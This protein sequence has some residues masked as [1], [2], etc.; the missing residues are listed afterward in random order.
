VAIRLGAVRLVTCASP[1][2]LARRGIPARPPDLDGHCCVT[3]TALSTPERW[4]FA[5]HD[6][7]LHSRL[8][9]NPAEAAI[10]AVEAGLGI[11]RVL[12]YQV[13]PLLRAGRLVTLLDDFA[14][15]VVPVSLIH[16]GQGRMPH[17]LRAFLDFAA[18]RLRATLK[19]LETAAATDA[20]PLS[21]TSSAR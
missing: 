21:G 17:K 15:D 8:T 16:A 1:A 5:G 2:Y 9:V 4:S 7:S 20:D 11:T 18:P 10:D 19:M 6:V 12:S 13:D 14:P 3:F